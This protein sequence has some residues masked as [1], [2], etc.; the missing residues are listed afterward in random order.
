MKS[1]KLPGRLL[2]VALYALPVIFCAFTYVLMTATA[3]DVLWKSWMFPNWQSAA[4]YAFGYNARLSDMYAY[5]A[6]TIFDYKFSFGADTVLRLF[7]TLMAVG[8]IYLITAAVLARRPRLRAKDGMAF[9]LV[10]LF[11][12]L[13]PYC[14]SLML[15]LSHIHNYLVIGIF[16]AL[17]LLP[18]GVKLRGGKLPKGVW[19]CPVML[20]CGFLFGFSSNV[21]PAAFLVAAACYGIY[22]LF[23]GERPG[24]KRLLTSWEL[25]AVIGV[26]AACVLMYGFGSGVSHYTGGYAA[27]D[28]ISLSDVL[29]DPLF[30]AFKLKNHIFDNSWDF[31]PCLAALAVSLIAET[32]LYRKRLFGNENGGGVRFSAVCLLFVT[33]HTLAVSQILINV[34]S[35][36]LLR[37]MMPAYFVTVAGVGFT[38]VRLG[39]LIA[40]DGRAV[41]AMAAAVALTAAAVTAD[42]GRFKVL[43]HRNTADILNY[44]S[45]SEGPDVYV[46]R[47]VLDDKRSKLFNFDQYPFVSDWIMPQ[48]IDGKNII[49]TD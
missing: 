19:F 14:D 33:M 45:E 17:F 22:L 47:S 16:S 9:S 25:Y 24:L 46:S 15:A 27:N 6:D 32:A 3:E 10:F 44:I 42:M 49:L 43:Q 41:T 18:F 37:L 34:D 36:P 23:R 7:D 2:S 30:Y 11:V 20:V 26:L 13:S 48:N 35:N 38:L 28:Y 39:R 12:Y 21:T 40:P 1:E 31:A 5:A 4:S 8:I 29:S